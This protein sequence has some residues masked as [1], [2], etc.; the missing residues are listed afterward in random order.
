[1]VI[2][3]NGPAELSVR[4]AVFLSGVLDF[5][6]QIFQVAANAFGCLAGAE[7]SAENGGEGEKQREAN[8]GVHSLLG[9]FG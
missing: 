6:S 4:L 2:G 5:I 8:R 3:D 9:V 7:N 1:L